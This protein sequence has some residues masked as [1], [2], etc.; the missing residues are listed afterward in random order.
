V[1]ATT[2]TSVTV[3][4]PLTGISAGTA[5]TVNQAY[6]WNYQPTLWKSVTAGFLRIYATPNVGSI[7]VAGDL[8]ITNPSDITTR[9]PATVQWSQNFGLNQMPATWEPTI[10][11]VANQLEVPVRGAV[12]D[13][14]P[15]NGQLFICSYWD[16]VVFSPINY[17]TTSAPIIGVRQF[18]QGRG[19]LNPSCSVNTDRI[20]YGIDARDVWRFD[21]SD[22]TG[23]GNQRVKNW[24]F[25]QI[26]PAYSD[27]VHMEVNTN[28]NQVEIYYP[29]SNAVNGVPNKM[30]SYRYDLDVWNPPRDV[31]EAIFTTESPVFHLS[32]ST[33]SA[34]AASRTVVYISTVANSKIIM[35][36]QGTAFLTTMAN[37]TG[38]INSRFRRDNIKVI[39][40]YSGK[41]MVHRIL[42]EVNNVDNKGVTVTPST[43]SIDIT[44]EGANSVGS[45]SSVSTPVTMQLA[46]DNPWCQINQ[47]AFRINNLEVSDSST[48]DT[49]ICS[50]ITWQF[51]QVEDDR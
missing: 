40:D 19:L 48:T 49:W 44:I 31:V 10:T 39:A 12:Q 1:I 33:W 38:A 50:A 15:S 17:S 35:K 46:T 32:G 16:T 26:D 22:F 18:N 28:K 13:A 30:V 25:D 20:V 14:F 24:L 2:T 8:T 42:P 9:Y 43:G 5:M 29:D 36:D 7:L 21:G 47:N 3:A 4:C 11:N 27:M 45:A 37:P 34:D 51:T 23:L 6:V 41:V